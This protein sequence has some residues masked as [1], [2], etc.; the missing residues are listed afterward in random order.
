MIYNNNSRYQKN[1]EK[2]VKKI[3]KRNIS[4]NKNGE[5]IGTYFPSCRNPFSKS[6]DKYM[7]LHLAIPR[8]WFI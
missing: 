8:A 5:K 4:W 2:H 3:E 1:D 7:K 6:S